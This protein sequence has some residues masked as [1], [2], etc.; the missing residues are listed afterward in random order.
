MGAQGGFPTFRVTRSDGEVA[1]IPDL[2]AR[3]AE[4]QGCGETGHSTMAVREA[5][6]VL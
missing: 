1:P 6:L 2:R 3:T 5:P 4:L